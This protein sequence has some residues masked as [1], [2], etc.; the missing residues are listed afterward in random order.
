MSAFNTV[1]VPWTDPKSGNTEDLRIQF[2]FGDTWQHEYRIGD[3]LLW[4]GNDVGPRDAK[5]VVVDGALEGEA[6]NGINED[7]EV[8]VRDGI[9]ERALPASG[10]FDFVSADENYIVLES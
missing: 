1:I 7:F 8:H 6:P 5:Y 9:I 4:G 2:K 10:N 3:K